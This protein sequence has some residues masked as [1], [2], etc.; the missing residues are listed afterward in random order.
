MVYRL[1]SCKA[2]RSRNDLRETGE[3]TPFK[4]DFDGFCLLGQTGIST[5]EDL[6][7]RPKYFTRQLHPPVNWHVMGTTSSHGFSC[8]LCYVRFLEGKLLRGDVFFPR[9][10]IS[11]TQ[12][13]G[14]S[15]QWVHQRGHWLCQEAVWEPNRSCFGVKLVGSLDEIWWFG[16]VDV[17]DTS[18]F[19]GR[20]LP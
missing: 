11:A 3:P 18:S 4:W 5:T 1:L 17:C 20:M 9:Q 13:R 12:T 15:W 19:R 10:E 2:G 8:K 7:N 14:F 6:Q 16:Y